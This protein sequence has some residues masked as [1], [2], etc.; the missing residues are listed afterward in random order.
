MRSFI[1]GLVAALVLVMPSVAHS[2]AYVVSASS[3]QIHTQAD[4]WISHMRE[5]MSPGAIYVK[6]IAGSAAYYDPATRTVNWGWNAATSWNQD[7]FVHEVGHDFAYRELAP[8]E[9]YT[10]RA[11][12]SLPWHESTTVY[13]SAARP[14]VHPVHEYFADWYAG[15]M[16]AARNWIQ[17]DANNFQMRYGAS[18]VEPSPMAPPYPTPW[19]GIWPR[20]L[21]IERCQQIPALMQTSTRNGTGGG[22]EG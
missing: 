22:V 4:G 1:V 3:G 18:A 11:W 12:F 16:L 19:R 7:N 13:H 2:Y 20:Y 21:T 10:F 14:S 9:W 17:Y 15:C 8:D 6:V 5:Y